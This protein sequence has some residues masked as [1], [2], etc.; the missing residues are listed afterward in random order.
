MT[1]AVVHGAETF[2]TVAEAFLSSHEAA[3]GTIGGST[4]AE[5]K[6]PA[7]DAMILELGAGIDRYYGTRTATSD[8]QILWS[9]ASGLAHGERWYATLTGGRRAKV[10]DVLT[11]RSLDV[12]CSG[13]NVTNLQLLTLATL[14]TS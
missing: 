13:I 12:V 11:R 6:A 4:S 9:A 7:D 10:A 1:K 2:A 14:R 8:V 5:K 3:L